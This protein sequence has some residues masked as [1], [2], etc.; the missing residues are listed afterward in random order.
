LSAVITIIFTWPFWFF[1]NS[2]NQYSISC[3]T[4]KWDFCATLCLRDTNRILWLLGLM[5]R[6]Q[7]N[8]SRFAGYQIV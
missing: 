3:F 7:T 5:F 6:L 1:L 2:K 8:I 4:Y